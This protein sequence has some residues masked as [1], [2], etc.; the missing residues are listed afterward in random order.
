MSQEGEMIAVCGL[1]QEGKKQDVKPEDIHCL[2]CRQDRAKHRSADCWILQCCV[3]KEGRE[4]CCR[5][6]EF[7]CDGL[8]EW[9]K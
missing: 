2:G 9:S 8:V 3:D 1:L 4:F 6:D 7:P 5:C